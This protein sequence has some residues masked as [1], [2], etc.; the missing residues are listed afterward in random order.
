[1]QS[2]HI[3]PHH[4]THLVMSLSRD[5]DTTTVQL[6]IMSLLVDI[7]WN[8]N[9][10]LQQH[11]YSNFT[12][13]SP[14][15]GPTDV[16]EAELQALARHYLDPSTGLYNYLRFHADIKTLE[17]EEEGGECSEPPRP[18]SAKVLFVHAMEHTC[19]LKSSHTI[20][21]SCNHTSRESNRP[22]LRVKNSDVSAQSRALFS[23]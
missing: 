6:P 21:Y 14:S 20:Y 10:E 18:S 11:I 8:T 15:P 23:E 5:S 22:M 4:T 1:M 9:D 13:P 7:T 19:L 16:S 12:F 3:P 2:S 17:R